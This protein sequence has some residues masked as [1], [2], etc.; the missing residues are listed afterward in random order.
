MKFGK[1]FKKSSKK[2]LVVN[3]YIVKNIQNLKQNFIM[4]KSIQIST[5]LK[6]QKKVLNVSAY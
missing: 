3:Q 1:K 5:A 6:C 2:I 4:E